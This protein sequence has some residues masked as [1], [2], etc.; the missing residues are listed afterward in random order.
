M[1]MMGPSPRS[2]V[3]IAETPSCLR[4]S[5]AQLTGKHRGMGGGGEGAV[6]TFKGAAVK[7]ER[8]AKTDETVLPF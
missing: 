6:N 8:G 7:E 1:A 3:R 4:A 5:R 2:G